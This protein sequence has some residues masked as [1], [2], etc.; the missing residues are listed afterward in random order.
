ME[1]LNQG[2]WD[3]IVKESAKLREAANTMGDR[4]IVWLGDNNYE[5]RSLVC[6][7]TKNGGYN[8]HDEKKERYISS[9]KVDDWTYYAVVF[10]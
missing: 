4:L 5:Y 1:K 3:A 10:I 7:S 9:E 6:W 8:V 2:E